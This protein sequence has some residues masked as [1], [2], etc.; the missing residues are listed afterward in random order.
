[1][2]ASIVLGDLYFWDDVPHVTGWLT[3]DGEQFE[4]AGVRHSKVRMRISGRRIRREE[5]A[6]KDLFDDKGSGEGG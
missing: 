6:Q 2:P 4:I 5:T 1:M 3:L